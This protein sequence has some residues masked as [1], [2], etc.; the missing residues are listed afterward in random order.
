MLKKLA[1]IDF[2]LKARAQTYAGNKGQVKP[3]LAGSR[4]YEYKS[5]KLLYRDIYN[6]GKGRFVG[7]ETIYLNG[8][9]IWSMSYYG[10]FEKMT[11]EEV[12]SVLRKAL[13]TKWDR[14]RLWHKVSYQVN[15]YT[16]KNEGSGNADQFDG[17]E[18]IQKDGQTLYYFYYASGVID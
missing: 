7:L 16:Y 5:G 15:G 2:L 8:Q 12:D 17:G 1:F 18:T 10:N 11:E 3:L 9:P 14:V 13:I 4:Q 6:I